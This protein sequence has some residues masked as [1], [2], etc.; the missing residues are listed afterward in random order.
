MKHYEEE[1][2]D[3]KKCGGIRI[4]LYDQ[5]MEVVKETNCDCVK[6][7]SKIKPFDEAIKKL[8]KDMKNEFTSK[9]KSS[10]KDS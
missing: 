6:K 3:C 9:T 10:S 1:L 2:I 8:K 7:K 4:F 5:F